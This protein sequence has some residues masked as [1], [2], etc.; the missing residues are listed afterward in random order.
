MIRKAISTLVMGLL[1]VIALAQAPEV[2]EPSSEDDIRAALFGGVPG[3]R[4]KE[5]L[6][7]RL[8]TCP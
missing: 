1:P 8:T 7:L 6:L 4:W 3:D 5:G 2:R